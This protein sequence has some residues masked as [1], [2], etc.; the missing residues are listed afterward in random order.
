ME[1]AFPNCIDLRLIL[2]R[3]RHMLT[4]NSGNIGNIVFKREVTQ[5]ALRPR[6][7]RFA[8]ACSTGKVVVR[9]RRREW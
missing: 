1:V 2:H 6:H 4:R 7:K 8:H 5:H 3:S 9:L